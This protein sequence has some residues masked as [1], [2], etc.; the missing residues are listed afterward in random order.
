MTKQE[1]INAINDKIAKLEE[2]KNFSSQELQDIENCPELFKDGRFDIG[3]KDINKSVYKIFALSMRK[4]SSDPLSIPLSLKNEHIFYCN[5]DDIEDSRVVLIFDLLNSFCINLQG[6]RFDSIEKMEEEMGDTIKEIVPI[7][8]EKKESIML[9]QKDNLKYKNSRLVILLEI[10]GCDPEDFLTLYNILTKEHDLFNEAA[11]RTISTAFLKISMAE[12]L[13]KHSNVPI[14]FY[15]KDLNKVME[16]TGITYAKEQI[17]S[18]YRFL[19]AS[20]IKNNKLCAKKQAKYKKYLEILKRM[21][22]DKIFLDISTV[23]SDIADETLQKEILIFIYNHNLKIKESLETNVK[24]LGEDPI[25]ANRLLFEKYGINPTKEAEQVLI[26]MPE[27]ALEIRLKTLKEMGITDSSTILKIIKTSDLNTMI[28]MK[29]LHS[30]R[31]LTKDFI[32]HHTEIFDDKTE[33]YKILMSNINLFIRYGAPFIALEKNQDILLKD[34][35]QLEEGLQ[36]MREYNLISSI[37]RGTDLSFLTFDNLSEE[38]DKALELGYGKN[39]SSNLSLL[40]YGSKT[41]DRVRL[42]QSIGEEITSNSQL[43]KILEDYAFLVPDEKLSEYIFDYSPEGID[44]MLNRIP[45]Q[46]LATDPEELIPYINDE[47]TYNIEDII[48]SRIK[49]QRNLAKLPITNIPK[50]K[51]LF[52]SIVNNSVLSIEECESI[53]KVCGLEM[54]KNLTK[55]FDTQN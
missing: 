4:S 28:N 39:I 25:L 51:K 33:E 40:K 49:V 54:S 41:W 27:A 17:L 20:K 6:K 30:K 42:A 34:S 36:T 26:Y 11:K 22:D 12:L 43:V 5:D 55:K 46:G 19:A 38:I 18:Y 52:Y 1:I 44:L 8:P 37:K 47:L 14:K 50:S 35:K 15:Q 31:I 48:I 45:P 21:P 7:L 13:E 16:E 32:T 2:Q 3:M 29:R 53:G 24:K 23:V 10:I 9:L